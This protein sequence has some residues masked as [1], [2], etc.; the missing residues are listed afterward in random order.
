MATIDNKLTIGLIR[1]EGIVFKNFKNFRGQFNLKN[2][3]VQ[4]SGIVFN[5]AF[6]FFFS[7][8]KY[9]ATPCTTDIEIS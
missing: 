7:F 4:D 9:N 1:R 8:H 2:H 6:I 3:S 5:Y